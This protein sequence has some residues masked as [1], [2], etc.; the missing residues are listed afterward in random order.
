MKQQ[1]GYSDEMLNAYI[2]GEFTVED[3]LIILDAMQKD[4]DLLSRVNELKRIK[5]LVTT[6]YLASDI[7]EKSVVNKSRTS[8]SLVASV[9]LMLGVVTG[10]LS[11]DMFLTDN[12]SVSKS[13]D[14]KKETWNIVLHVNTNDKYIQKTI[15]DETESLLESFKESN[16]KVKVEIVAYGKGVLLFDKDKSKYI[17]RLISLRNNFSNLS[18]VV[19]GRTIKRLEKKQERQIQLISEMTVARSGIYQI[20]KRQKQGWNYI[21]I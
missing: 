5:L 13:F 7:R 14:T 19:C 17:E 10:W 18:Y 2:D 21:R 8:L 6:T 3:E 12:A 15:L 11:H 1:S 4:A 9:V 20:I 16:Q